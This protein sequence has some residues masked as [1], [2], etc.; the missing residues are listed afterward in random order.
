MTVHLAGNLPPE[1]LNGLAQQEQ[2][3]MGGYLARDKHLIVGVVQVTGVKGQLK[4]GFALQPIVSLVH[5]EMVPG[6]MGDDVLGLLRRLAQNRTTS[7]TI[8][9]PDDETETEPDAPLELEAGDGAYEYEVVDQARG[10]F[11]LIVRTPSGAQVTKR[12]NLMRKE[13]GDIPPGVYQL[14]HLV[15]AP[16][17]QALATAIVAEY[18]AGMLDHNADDVVDAEVVDDEGNPITPEDAAWDA[19][20]PSE[21]DNGW[22]SPQ[23]DDGTPKDE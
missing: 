4:E 7:E 22:T 23:F 2:K 20:A 13:Y 5:V 16:E 1:E 3:L 6:E 8:D 14:T 11:G 10:R 12:S 9:F 15:E 17:L 21:P 18:E 19:A